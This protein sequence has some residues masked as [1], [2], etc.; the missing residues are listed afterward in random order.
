MKRNI[1]VSSVLI[2][3]GLNHTALYADVYES[4][5]Q[6]DLED[7]FMDYYGGEEFVSI[8]TGTQKSVSKAPAVASVITADQIRLM[9]ATDIDE[10]LENVPG[11]HVTRRSNSNSPIY[12][13]RGIFTRFNPQVLMLINGIP[14][15]NI[16]VGNRGQIWGG[17]PV[18]AISRIEVIRGPGSA[19]YG[20]DAFSG[21]INIITKTPDEI[22]ST[23]FGARYGSFNTW[24]TWFATSGK[25]GEYSASMVY[26]YHDTDGHNEIIDADAQTRLDSLLG[27]NASLAPGPM[28]NFRTHH[29]LRL[30][31]HGE[32]L[33]MRAG[34]QE[35]E[36]G[37]GAG[38][39]EALSPSTVGA[40]TRI[41]ADVTYAVPNMPENASLT[42][43]GNYF[44]ATQEYD[45]DL[46]LYPA[47]TDLGGGV[48]PDGVVGNPEVFE[49]HYRGAAVYSYDGYKDHEIRLGTGYNFNEIYKVQESKNFALGPNGE[50]LLPG[51]PIVDVSDTPFVFLPERARESYYFYGQDIWQI[52]NDWEMTTGVRYDK[53]NDFGSTANPRL[54]LVWSTSLKLTTK[55]LYGKA[56]RA[57]SFANLYNINNPAALGNPDLNPEKIET[58]EIAFDYRP[59]SSFNAALSLFHYEWKDIIRFQRDPGE[60]AT[61]A[62]NT[63]KNSGEGFELEFNWKASSQLDL[64]GN[65]SYQDS[66]N[67]ETDLVVDMVPRWQSHLLINYQMSDTW[68]MNWSINHIANRDRDISDNRQEIEDYTLFNFTL[69]WH[70]INDQ[71]S[72]ALIV[73]NIFNKD[74]REPTPSNNGV[75]NIPGDLP[76]PRRNISLEVRYKF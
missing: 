29:D 60:I 49:R 19:V 20:A 76:L 52:S 12:V 3:L 27:T 54:A 63:G 34:I 73:K 67:D 46:I 28:V 2:A 26:E 18:E 72:T 5:Y 57:P 62:Q 8:A 43:S 41:N 50:V 10:I 11:L 74:A 53:Y 47:G 64:Q 37:T 1:L 75:A 44:S 71:F 22:G 38:I 24:D 59:S 15:T 13:I 51:S 39:V 16:F 58:T 45:S 9:G 21:T 23:E 65:F 33:T 17:M 66:K 36:V 14:I 68:N 42:L 35:R 55:F 40:S 4:N 61:V 25:L 70:D 6:S 32:N 48:Y 56:F 7:E 30:E 31:L 69:R